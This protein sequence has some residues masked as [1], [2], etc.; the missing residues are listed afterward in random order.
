ML[1]NILPRENETRQQSHKTVNISL[2][3][4]TGAIERHT[5]TAP[6][7][8]VTCAAIYARFPG[9]VSL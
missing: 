3:P 7:L 6:F 1:L 5:R 2:A 4:R 8:S 9:I